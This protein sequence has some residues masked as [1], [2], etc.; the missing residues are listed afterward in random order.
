[1]HA[2]VRGTVSQQDFSPAYIER[3]VE[4]SLRRLKTDYIDLYQ[5]HSPPHDALERGD[6]VEALEKLRQQGKIR[7]WGVACEEPRDVLVALQQPSLESVQVAFSA[8]EQHALDQA[9]PHALERKVGIIARQ[10]FAS[11]LLTRSVET[12]QADH[13]D[14]VPAVAERKRQ[15]LTAYATIAERSG[16]TRAELALHFALARPEVG[17][18]LLGI[19]RQEQLDSGLKAL[20][21]DP[22]SAQEQQLLSAL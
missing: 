19:S 21:A 11:G 7:H 4:A 6:Y 15:L 18:V 12:I 13:L 20:R 14:R 5:L 9:F 8:L 1:V 22:L 3:A 10:V 17:V 2:G 16:R